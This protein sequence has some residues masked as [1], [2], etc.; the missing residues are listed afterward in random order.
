MAPK[1]TF[2]E[3]TCPAVRLDQIDEAEGPVG[4]GQL[5]KNRMKF[6]A[7]LV[8]RHEKRKWCT[9]SGSYKHMG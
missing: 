7:F 8:K 9:D 6:Q 3:A 5:Q 2:L 1:Q 4:R